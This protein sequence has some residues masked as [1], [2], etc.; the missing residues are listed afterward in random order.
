MPECTEHFGLTLGEDA[1]AG[2][3]RS[4]IACGTLASREAPL[5]LPLGRVQ[6][7]APLPEPTATIGVGRQADQQKESRACI[8]LSRVWVV[9]IRRLLPNWATIDLA[10]LDP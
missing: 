3:A 8:V 6:D 1:A 7:F 4:G 2:A 10:R 9:F 5:E